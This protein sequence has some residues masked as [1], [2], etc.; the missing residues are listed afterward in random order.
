MK[1]AK[2]RDM[3]KQKLSH[4]SCRK[5]NENEKSITAW[6]VENKKERKKKKKHSTKKRTT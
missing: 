4:E 3:E 6:K 1:T 5:G 2:K